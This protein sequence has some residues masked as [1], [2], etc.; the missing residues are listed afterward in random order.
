MASTRTCPTCQTNP[1]RANGECKT[2]GEYRRRNGRPRPAHL[3]RRQADLN[4][5]RFED[6]IARRG[7]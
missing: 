7:R 3:A 5:R 1:V 2:C 4:R 6:R